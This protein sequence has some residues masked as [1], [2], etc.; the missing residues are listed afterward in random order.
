VIVVFR[1]AAK[2]LHEKRS[3]LARA[4]DEIRWKHAANRGRAELAIEG[5]ECLAIG[6]LD[7][8]RF[9]VQFERRVALD[10]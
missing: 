10:D 9:E 2:K 1:R 4:C 7:F 5:F 6:R 8:E 3:R